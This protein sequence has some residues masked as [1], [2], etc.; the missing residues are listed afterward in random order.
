MNG[1]FLAFKKRHNVTYKTDTQIIVVSV[2]SVTESQKT[3]LITR[4]SFTD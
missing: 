4:L 3:L 2:T 1:I